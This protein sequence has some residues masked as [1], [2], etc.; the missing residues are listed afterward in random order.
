MSTMNTHAGNLHLIGG[1]PCLDFVNSVFPHKGAIREYL[2]EYRDLLAWSLHAGMIEPAEGALLAE[3]A[4][5]DPTRAAQ[6]FATALKLRGALDELLVATVVEATPPGALA[7]FN[8]LLAQAPARQRL[9]AGAEGLA[10]QKHGDEALDRLL[11]PLIWSAADLLLSP[12]LQQIR[13]CAGEDC[14]WRFLDTTPGRT[15]QWCAMEPC[16]NR[17]K[18]RRHYAR[19]NE[20]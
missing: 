17:A 11:W 14:S 13:V 20:R 19:R 2:H 7:A 18:A 3:A 12:A 8:E 15:R 9:F 4:A 10:W 5:A 1:H 6:A 16:G